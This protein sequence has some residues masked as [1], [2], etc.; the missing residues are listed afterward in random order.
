MQFKVVKREHV[1]MNARAVMTSHKAI[2][3]RADSFGYSGPVRYRSRMPLEI[4]LPRSHG[5][6]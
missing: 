3:M 2:L 4:T 1:S 6:S 5:F